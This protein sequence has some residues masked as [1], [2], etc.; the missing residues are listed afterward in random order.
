MGVGLKSKP[1]SLKSYVTVV[2]EK[3][4]GVILQ[5]RAVQRKARCAPFMRYRKTIFIVEC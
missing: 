1:L 4:Q 3:V 2:K 5:Y